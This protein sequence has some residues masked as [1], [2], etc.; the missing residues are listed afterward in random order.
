MTPG[1]QALRELVPGATPAELALAEDLTPVQVRVAV[2][3]LAE[4]GE[5]TP[6]VLERWHVYYIAED[7]AWA[8]YIGKTRWRWASSALGALLCSA[9]WRVHPE[10]GEVRAG[11]GSPW[12]R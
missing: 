11:A 5:P 2:R 10:T 6:T 9:S 12:S 7:D 3:A 8:A 4:A 1:Q